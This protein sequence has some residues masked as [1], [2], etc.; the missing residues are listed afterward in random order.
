[1]RAA[2]AALV[3]AALL[4][5]CSGTAAPAP[6]AAADLTNPRLSIERSQWLVGPI[7]RLASREEVE[8]YLRLD[9][10]AA[11]AQFEEAF[12]QRRDPDPERPG[13]PARDLF[14]RRAAEADRRFAEAGYRGR[15]TDR[16]VVLVLHG[17]PQK[18]D[19]ELSPQRDGSPIE[20]WSFPRT[21]GP[22]LNGRPP[23]ETYRFHKP[24][25]LTVIYQRPAEEPS[26]PTPRPF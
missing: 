14:E 8:A 20:V 12:W 3:A 22:G 19:F 5:G 10:D 21:A 6:R 18:V 17:E 26:P 1:M 4:A 2:L 7:A 13:N 25:D 11:A 15:R 16:G 24:D 9:D 23:A